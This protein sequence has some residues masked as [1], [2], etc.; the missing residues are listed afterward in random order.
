[1]QTQVL[2]FCKDTAKVSSLQLLKITIKSTHF[3]SAKKKI[4]IL[5]I[6][7]LTNKIQ[8]V[9]KTLN[10]YLKSKHRAVKI[11]QIAENI[12][13]NVNKGAT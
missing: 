4:T 7:P 1:M 13:K 2:R 9:I 8:K 6:E 3:L 5:L 10:K 12:L 11:L